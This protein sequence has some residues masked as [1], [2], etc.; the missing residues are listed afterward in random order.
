MKYSNA[1]VFIGRAN[2]NTVNETEAFFLA[3]DVS[4]D[5]PTSIEAKR[6]LGKSI[7]N[8]DQFTFS[9][10]SVV[11]I[12]LNFYVHSEYWEMG[13][14]GA[15]INQASYLFLYDTFPINS[16]EYG[17][18]TGA[19]SFPIKIGNNMFGACKLNE[20]SYSIRP[21]E[22]VMGKASFSCFN[23]PRQETISGDYSVSD[24]SIDASMDAN[25][26][27]YG[28]TCV[29]SNAGQVVSD[30]VLSS[31]SYSKKYNRSP[32]YGIGST[33]PVRYLVDKVE[34]DMTIES[35]GLASL[36]DYSGAK[37]TSD[38]TVSLLDH[39]A[40][41]IAP[42][43]ENS[44]LSISFPSGARVTSEKYSVGEGDF[45]SSSVEIKHILV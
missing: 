24:A 26:V 5:Y 6:K 21:F 17:N 13:W 30:T 15:L 18:A 20:I 34:A 37:L 35:T 10:P 43:G 8:D 9:G 22:P 2:E 45:V 4:V 29:V 41:G 44:A 1:P 25:R 28:N 14:T 42:S 32:I 36:I 38:I 40:S 23:P 3:K 11:S 27:I 12:D 16:V 31:I 19:N 39:S 7:D 33:L